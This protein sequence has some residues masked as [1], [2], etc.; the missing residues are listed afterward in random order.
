MARS[1]V[2]IAQ[3]KQFK[4][5]C[6]S[7][8]SNSEAIL[9]SFR[10]KVASMLSDFERKLDELEEDM[11]RKEQALSSCEWSHR[12]DDGDHC[13]SQRS[14]YYRAQARYNRCLSLVQEAQHAI[15]E[16]DSKAESFRATKADLVSRASAGLDRVEALIVEYSTGH[17]TQATDSPGGKI[18]ISSGPA[19][20]GKIDV[21][22]SGAQS[23]IH[24]SGGEKIA[25]V[26]PKGSETDPVYIDMEVT[27][28]KFDDLPPIQE[29]D[30]QTMRLAATGI[31]ALLAAG[32]LAVGSKEML[33]QQK[34]DEI[35]QSQY[36][37]SRTDLLIGTG[38]KQKE[39]VDAYN[40]IY[41]GLRQEIVE[42]KKEEVM[43]K[44]QEARQLLESE[45]RR[46]NELH[47]D[48][49]LYST[50]LVHDKKIE[51]ENLERQLATLTDGKKRPSVPS[52][53]TEIG[54][55]SEAGL[56]FMME[57]MSTKERFAT[58]SNIIGSS[59]VALTGDSGNAYVFSKGDTD[60]LFVA[61]DGSSVDHFVRDASEGVSFKGF[62]IEAKPNVEYSTSPVEASK[63]KLEDGIK[64]TGIKA[65][66]KDEG[67]RVTRKY[68][69]ISE[70]GSA[71]SWGTEVKLG[72]E[73]SAEV[74]ATLKNM[75]L[76]GEASFAKAG[77]KASHITAPVVMNGKISQFEFGVSGD[78]NAGA[79]ASVG[80]F[81]A[82]DGTRELGVKL[83]GGKIAAILDRPTLSLEA[84]PESIRDH[85]QTVIPEKSD[86]F[87]S[88]AKA[89]H[90]G[91]RPMI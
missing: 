53:K 12:N 68:Y 74:N 31:I 71:N 22:S 16:F 27:A 80:V 51:V 45:E 29:P 72:A 1:V 79:S 35:F 78:I 66:Y 62:S 88:Y 90:P 87:D 77:A 15:D 86:L 65:T 55:L 40:R 30:Q 46:I 64:E 41:Q 44:I 25:Y 50:E 33:L 10:E 83:P 59:N 91:E 19:I 57:G 73:A 5:V 82:D 28:H 54:G 38:R 49:T 42:I 60:I 20:P 11:D 4:A 3:I 70:D 89:M 48:V 47:G 34:T 76:G 43:D 23:A 52:G 39:Y 9:N 81:S 84:F 63:V 8:G 69:S 21:E 13:S 37:I 14:A 17:T 26:L 56:S 24:I 32:G 6:V 85:M 58:V 2:S 7:Y 67:F 61:Y 36:G 18:S 75:N